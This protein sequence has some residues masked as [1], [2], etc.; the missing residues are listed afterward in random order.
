[1]FRLQFW[2]VGDFFV[3][4]ADIVVEDIDLRNEPGQVFLG[5]LFIDFP[6]VQAEDI[7]QE[8]LAFSRCL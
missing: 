6:L 5:G 3:E 7:G 1:M 2:F 4:A 8:A